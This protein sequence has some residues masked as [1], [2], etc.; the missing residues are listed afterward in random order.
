[1]S[2]TRVITGN[3]TS[4]YVEALAVSGMNL[5]AATARRTGVFLSNR[6]GGKLD[7]VNNGLTYFNFSALLGQSGGGI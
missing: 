2:W 3:L 6:Q 5:F 1:M 4:P 7:S